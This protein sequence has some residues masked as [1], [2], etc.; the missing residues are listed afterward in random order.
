[1][2]LW[3]RR[4]AVK[5]ALFGG[6][7]LGIVAMGFVAAVELVICGVK[8][9]L[10]AGGWALK[11]RWAAAVAGVL[12]AFGPLLG[13]AAGG[14]SIAVDVAANKL[15]KRRL[16]EPTWAAR[17]YVALL[18]LPVALFCAAVFH[19]RRARLIPYKDLWAVLMGAAFLAVAYV[20]AWALL[21]L[22][23][24]VTSGRASQA[25]AWG[26]FAGLL[27][28]SAGFMVADR[29]ILP[30]LYGYFHA[31]LSV[32]AVLTAFLA[33][34]LAY[35][36]LKRVGHKVWAT[37]AEPKGA[38]AS[39]LLCVA[40]GALCVVH[41]GRSQKLRAVAFRR[42]VMASKLLKVL[43]GAGMLPAPGRLKAS[44][45]PELMAPTALG[46]RRQSADLIL[47]T[48]DA[49]RADHVGLYGYKRK[50]TPN[51]DRIFRRG[52]RFGRAYTPMPQTSYALASLITGRYL[53]SPR[54]VA[55]GARHVTLAE[56]L[57]RFGYKT[58]AFYPPSMFFIDRRFF[59][60]PRMG[61][62]YS[63][64][65]YH[66]TAYDDDAVGRT[67]RVIR[68]VR[69]WVEDRKKGKDSGRHLFVWVHYFDPHHPYQSRKGF[70][71]GSSNRGRYLSEVAYVDAQ[72]GRL[73]A[74]MEKVRPGAVF[75]LTGDHGEAFGE[76]DSS[77]HGTTLY[78]EQVRVP[79]LI[80]GK[81][82]PHRIVPNP[83]ELT[84]LAPTL[85]SLLDLSVPAAMEGTDLTPFM[86]EEGVDRLP[87]AFSEVH[88]PGGRM[89]MVAWRDHKLIRDHRTDTLELYNLK[90][91]PAEQNP[92]DFEGRKAER[93]VASVLLGHL[94]KWN[95]GSTAPVKRAAADTV[96]SAVERLR[97]T[98]PEGRRLAAAALMAAKPEPKNRALVVRLMKS[99]PDPEVR[100]RCAILAAR[101]G[102]VEA[103]DSVGR[104][105]K[106]ADLPVRMRASAAMAL[107]YAGRA[108]AVE[109]LAG[110]YNQMRSASE[111]RAI[112]TALG[113]LG[114]A[115]ALPTLLKALKE[116]GSKLRAAKAL[117]RLKDLRSAPALFEC[118]D[119]PG[120]QVSLRQAAASALARLNN[121][122]VMKELAKRL[123]SR[124]EILVRATLLLELS[125]ARPGS[126]PRPGWPG[127][128]PGR[129]EKEQGFDCGQKGCRPAPG[130]AL[131]LPARGKTGPRKQKGPG[132]TS[133]ELWLVGS[134]KSS[135]LPKLTVDDRAVLRIRRFYE[136]RVLRVTAF[137][138]RPGP[139]V[140]FLSWPSG[141]W[142]RHVVVRPA[143]SKS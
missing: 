73:Y 53:S 66:K 27:A 11:V 117:E 46:P 93:K 62:E 77:A 116:P 121:P 60:V 118:L 29:F 112:L 111:R 41:L 99:D 56:T 143:D 24:R 113:R 17:I 2:T 114:D 3:D 37:V 23:E 55:S 120:S 74:F 106:R 4:N 64:V 15:S 139:V 138:S 142:L 107:A 124:R 80:G 87:P 97:S 104:L 50:V 33:G 35:L 90:V 131:K 7:V 84:D 140:K 22:R 13:L 49:L 91:D 47:I 61:F 103:L 42:T 10:P 44:Q 69:K 36:R 48:I 89:E 85:L 38:A 34:F 71:F 18:L 59:T 45:P 16:Q 83:V 119:S 141:L 65:Q 30:G 72:V 123:D 19:G 39:A 43:H 54:K 79:F 94:E 28:C 92:L 95:T 25:E 136:G 5:R 57:R 78:D 26:A 6:A 110:L 82:I 98:D 51:I 32:L 127:L 100:H 31:A 128:G 40:V 76:H 8:G 129:F 75:V 115:R 67:D 137:A 58:A 63:V 101:L 88:V 102:D 9:A 12:L 134:G 122:K 21:N 135:V 20:L 52:V 132:D 86:G 109:E 1:M 70:N 133:I 68:F 108:I 126:L 105:L 81:G 125:D 96:A 130:T 14:V